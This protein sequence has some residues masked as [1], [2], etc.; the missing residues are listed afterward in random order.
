VNRKE[1]ENKM[2]INTTLPAMIQNELRQN[3]KAAPARFAVDSE[4]IESDSSWILLLDMPGM[5]REDVEISVENDHLLIQGL[6]GREALKEGEKRL[7]SGRHH[8][9]MG[10]RY[11][12]SEEIDREHISA[13]MDKGV[14]RVELKKVA[15]ALPKKIEIAVN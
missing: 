4:L 11:R 9:R 12:L 13:H 8:G 3:L 7:H 15:K 14:L 5:D 6:R 10:R 2:F 1:K